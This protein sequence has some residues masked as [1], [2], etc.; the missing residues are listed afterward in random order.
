MVF[1]EA[2]NNDVTRCYLEGIPCFNQDIVHVV[3]LE[4]RG[5]ILHHTLR[6]RAIVESLQC[7]VR[8]VVIGLVVDRVT[9]FKYEGMDVFVLR[10]C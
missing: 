5:T 3:R 7:Q 8:P 10:M 6:L 4:P 1:S 2:V 9:H